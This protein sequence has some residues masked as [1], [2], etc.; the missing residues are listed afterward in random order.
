MVETDDE[1][2]GL[3]PEQV[4]G[5]CRSI[6][7]KSRFLN[8]KGIG[9]N[10]RCIT[11]NGPTRESID[12]LVS[13]KRELED[14]LGL[15]M[16]ILSGGNSSIWDMITAG[17]LPSQVN[18]V[19]I[20]EAIFLG[21]ETAGYKR[22]DG[23]FQDCFVLEAEI[24]EVKSKNNIPYRIILALGLQDTALKDLIVSDGRLKPRSQSSDHTMLDIVKDDVYKTGEKDFSIF[25]VGGIISFNLNYFGLLSCMTS[26]FV[27]KEFI[28]SS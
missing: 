24:I 7:G 4:T 13:L 18:Q 21:H 22:I 10:A 14:T 12:I 8:I 9:T 1:R 11:S 19:R 23:A 28:S 3:L 25:K 26:P 2:E 27:E 20:G 6:M 15:E 17:E 5:F 16:E